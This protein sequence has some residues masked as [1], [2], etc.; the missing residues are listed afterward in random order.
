[1]KKIR[2]EKGYTYG[3]GSYL[4]I[5]ENHSELHIYLLRKNM[6]VLDE[7]LVEITK[8]QNERAI[9]KSLKK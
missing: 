5:E 1:M 4:I 6:L 9:K 3:I 2:E 7:I 8:L